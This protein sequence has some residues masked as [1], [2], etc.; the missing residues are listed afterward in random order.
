MNTKR[1]KLQRRLQRFLMAQYRNSSYEDTAYPVVR[2][3]LATL[4]E[5]TE[6]LPG[7]SETPPQQSA[8]NAAIAITETIDEL[9]LLLRQS[10]EWEE[11]KNSKTFRQTIHQNN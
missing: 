9:K 6:L 1:T 8:R 10:K 2:A 5:L 11:K 7:K 3:M 4:D